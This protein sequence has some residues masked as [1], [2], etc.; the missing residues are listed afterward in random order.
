[1]R[2]RRFII[3]LIVAL[4]G[5]VLWFPISGDGKWYPVLLNT[6][7]G[8]VF[9]LV[10]VLC[11]GV[12]R[13]IPRIDS[14]RVY[15]G[16]FGSAVMLGAV[17]ELLQVPIGRDADL[18]D[19]GRDALGAWIGLA[20]LAA[21]R[22]SGAVRRRVALGASVVVP[23]TILAVPV[24]ECIGAYWRRAAEFPVLVDFTSEPSQY[25]V[26][27]TET[28]LEW[29]ALPAAWSRT[30]GEHALRVEFFSGPYA[31]VDFLEPAA[32]WSGYRELV[33]DLTNPSQ[34]ALPL[35]LRVHDSAHDQSYDDR[36]N[37]TVVLPPAQ[38]AVVAIPLADIERGPRDRQLD[39]SSIADLMLFLSLADAPQALHGDIF[40]SR[41][42]LR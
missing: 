6:G 31:G 37:G 5:T 27:R 35:T 41:I 42:W 12:L 40:V 13:A 2:V 23:L 25:F 38:R 14:R 15:V 34:A 4:L 32:D 26:Q 7:H 8:V 17:V 28:V 9:A 19:V 29:T 10:A 1:V 21:F 3:P 16:A 20:L 11:H 36:Y 30:P 39:L 24:V 33:L 18:A 22:E